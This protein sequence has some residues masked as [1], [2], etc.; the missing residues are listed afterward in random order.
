MEKK[1]LLDTN[2]FI[3]HLRGYSPALAFFSSL[4]DKEI[5]FSAITESELLAG[6]INQSPEKRELLLQFLE[7]WRKVSVDNPLAAVAGDL[8]RVYKMDIPD[9]I[10]A[11]S[12]LQ[13]NSTLIT[14]N[15]KD[16]QKVKGQKLFFHIKN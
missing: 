5:S 16:F 12:A 1:I 3:D 9:A 8:S 14:K 13:E 6:S 15:L 4:S 11:A 10:I 2:I 7:Q